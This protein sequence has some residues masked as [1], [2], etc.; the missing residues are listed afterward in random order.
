MVVKTKSLSELTCLFSAAGLLLLFCSCA[1]PEPD[2]RKNPLYIDL[3]E[4]PLY[5]KNGFDPAGAAGIPDFSDG[6]WQ[7]R[8]PGEQ[9]TARIVKFLG[10]DTP[11]RFFLS[12]FEEKPREYT[13]A[14]PFTVSPE[15][16]EILN[17]NEPFQPG[18]FLAALGDNWA[19]FLNGHPVKSEVHLDKNGWIRSH[20]SWRYVS[21]PLDKAFFVPGTNMLA[22]RILGEPNGTD[23]GLWYSDPYYIGEYESIRK[24][25]DES[26]LIACCVV[27]IF[28]GI[29]HLLYY[30][31]RTRDKYH[32]SYC[33]FSILLGI[34]FL[35]R[36]HTIYSLIPDSN[37][38]FRIEYA[39]VFMVLPL[40]A[41]FLEHLNL[42]RIR[43]ITRI[44][45]IISLLLAAAQGIFPN[46]FRDDIL[47]LW[48]GF[49]LF[50]YV[51]ILVW[52]ILY[53]FWRNSLDQ[54]KL[55]GRRSLPEALWNC[56]TETPLGNIL[57]GTA[58]MAVTGGIDV[59]LTI[60]TKRGFFKFGPF[61]LL[62]F[63]I[64]TTVILSRR[65]G[66]LF[67]RLDEM[68]ILL[69]KSNE[70]LE[71]TVQERTLD[72]ERQTKAAESASQAK[73]QFLARMS[74]EIRTPLNAILGLSEVELQ[75][76][77]PETTRANIEK[78]YHSGA[79]L[80]EIVNDILD[81]SKIESGNF[82][83]FPAEYEF[84]K[85][86]NDAVQ[87]NI[88]RIGIKPIEFHL[89]V[90]ETLPLKVYGDELRMKQILNNL[91][92]NAIKYTEE[93][94]VCLRIQC[95]RRENCGWF[96]FTVED[97]GRGIKEEDLKKLFS[98]YTRLETAANRQTQGTGLGLSITRGL[99]EMMGGSISVESKYSKGSVFRV[100]LPQGIVDAR[101]IGRETAENL[102][103]LRFIEDRS[104]SRGN[105]L[106]RSYMPYGKVLVVDDLETNLDVMKGLL[107]PYGL[108]VDTLLSGREAVEAVREEKERYDVV[109]M[110]HMMPGMDGIEATRIIRK[111]INSEYARR[112][113]IIALTANA[114][115]GNKEMFL[116]SGF[117]DF[118]SKPIDIK[119]L[120]MVLNQWVRD[121]QSEATLREAQGRGAG[122]RTGGAEVDEEGR[123]LLEHP[124]EGVDFEGALILYGNSGAAYIPILKSYVTHTPA[125]LQRMGEHLE[126]SLLKD[127]AIEAH[128][129]KGTSNA[130]C[131]VEA[132]E[133]AREV[134]AAAKGGQT[135]EVRRRHGQVSG[136]VMGLIE[137][138][139]GLV[140]EWEAGLPVQEKPGKAEPDR[141]LL[142]RLCE[143][144]EEF[145]SNETE[146]ILRQLEG[147]RYE[148]GG[149][150]IGW[151]REQAEVFDYDAMHRRLKE[152][153]DKN[154]AKKNFM[155]D[156]SMML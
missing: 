136:R 51:Y 145:N 54:W 150:F 138:L 5:V 141:Q 140:E 107:L 89:E 69:E 103:G 50:E 109:F 13:M 133:L 96:S 147:Y 59:I 11:E 37:V 4:Y 129:L 26:L 99:V 114:V 142:G 48:W 64:T 115:A 30:L 67:R 128:G 108:K 139:R 122:S 36:G 73:S 22:L 125:L 38:S 3:N 76:K 39:S 16:F 61:G 35:T 111:R 84:P 62:V 95:E 8:R 105:S 102:R 10:L 117:T 113:A 87:L 126:A 86:I 92:S 46:L 110:D 90:E 2:A 42:G 93:G 149:E 45:G 143:A 72:L 85:L 19:I 151:L 77:L 106:I 15:Q 17:K 12:P 28:M 78:V 34:Y 53:V 123:W 68:N 41:A 40:L 144:T 112:V 65:F 81:I 49:Q 79:H 7:T 152:V 66:L 132:G 14:I 52:D 80:L 91:L 71:T 154:A 121:R 58:V 94:K 83:I 98:D 55:G 156:S 120:D 20:R 116:D 100:S 9:N 32:L 23:T 43:T 148:E 25:H 135:E 57:L 153:L 18:M 134:E 88:V 137:R 6:S 127:Y 97:S 146:E 75:K 60:L 74:H 119:R 24:D 118:I 124:V 1:A 31:N 104:R 130:V 29:Y 47:Y 63:T 70:N 44:C 33:L 56:F 21:F 131:A 27:Y 82:E 101:P 155:Y